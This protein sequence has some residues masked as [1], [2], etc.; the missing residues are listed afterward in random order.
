[1]SSDIDS[2]ME[3]MTSQDGGTEPSVNQQPHGG[4]PNPETW[5]VYQWVMNDDGGELW[6]QQA[7]EAWYDAEGDR[8][9]AILIFVDWFRDEADLA[10]PTVAGMYGPLLS[11]ALSEVDWYAIANHILDD[12]IGGEIPDPG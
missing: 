6:A 2:Y 11:L 5:A 8:D 12:A 10:M 1:M 3:W 7:R 4:W 9:L